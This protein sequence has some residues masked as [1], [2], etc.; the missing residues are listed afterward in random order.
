MKIVD[1][2]A[3]Y[4]PQGGGVR[5]YIEQKLRIGPQLGHEIVVIV[6]GERHEVIERGP[7]ARIVSL[8]SPRFP[9]DRKYGYFADEGVL[10]AALD[11]EK[12]DV[13][14][15]S[16]PW[17]SPS[18]VARWQGS[19]RRSLVMH[20]D[21]LSAYAYRW[22][23]PVL[24]RSH[25][26]RGFELYWEHLRHLGQ[27]FDMTVCANH[28]LAGRL[29]DGGVAGVCVHP[30]GVETG[31]FTPEQ[32]DPELR[33]RLLELCGLD[34][35]ARLLVAAGRLAPEKRWPMV[36]DAVAA[37]SQQTPVGL[38]LFGEGR[39]KRAI[40]SAIGGNPHVRLFEPERDRTAFAAILASAD[41]VVH[42]CEAETFCMVGAEARASGTPVIVPDCGGAADHARNAGSLTY[43][44]GNRFSLT[45]AIVKFCEQRQG[46]RSASWVVSNVQH[47]EGLFADY[48]HIVRRSKAA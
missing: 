30:L 8:P 2:C 38:V 9:L 23:E 36:V 43:K 44:A 18:M 34:Q 20:A 22:F 33:A 37:A 12:P 13:V 42:G 5:T 41:A 6:P 1:V 47:F 28:D 26:D 21:P 14:E 31:V 11:A 35:N 27:A 25:I 24:S 32:R 7:G 17:R 46:A 16:S 29:R 15:V 10:H 19:A 4:S 45:N 40:R 39:E 48:G 3:F